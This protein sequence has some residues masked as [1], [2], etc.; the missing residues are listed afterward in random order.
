VYLTPRPSQAELGRY[1]PDGYEAYRQAESPLPGLAQQDAGRA[2][3]L[4]LDWVEKHAPRR[5]R[6]LDVGCATGAFLNLAQARGWKVRGIELIE[7]AAQ[8]ARQRYGL[9][10]ITGDVEQASLPAG[11][12]DAIT[13]WDVLE[14]LP[15]PRRALSRCYDLL[16]PAGFIIFSIPNLASFDRYLFGKAWIGWDP[17]RHF[18]L[19]TQETMPRLLIETGFKPVERACL[20]GGKGTFL[21][22]LDLLLGDGR[23]GRLARALSPPLSAA[24][25]PYRQV[26]YALQRGPI[27]TYV[28]QKPGDV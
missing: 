27:I 1:Y 22:S 9:D 10:V 15:S 2:L 20:L 12:F 7:P 19:F 14:H 4:Q 26:A 13:L 3:N 17:P 5:G 24:L 6:L 18:N 16:K 28:A 23:L 8:I 25:W 11:S 21:L